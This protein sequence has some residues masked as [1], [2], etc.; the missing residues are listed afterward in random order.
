MVNA[1]LDVP[2][3][4][5]RGGTAPPSKISRSTGTSKVTRSK[6]L[7]SEND[8]GDDLAEDLS[9]DVSDDPN[10]YHKKTAKAIIKARKPATYG[11]GNARTAIKAMFTPGSDTGGEDD[12]GQEGDESDTEYVAAGAPFLDYPSGSE[13]SIVVKDEVDPPP[14]TNAV[15]PTIRKLVKLRIPRRYAHQVFGNISDVSTGGPGYQ[16]RNGAASFQVGA[17]QIDVSQFSTGPFGFQNQPPVNLQRGHPHSTTFPFLNESFGNGSNSSPPPTGS[18][19]QDCVPSYRGVADPLSIGTSAAEQFQTRGQN[20]VSN[21]SDIYYPQT[22][23]P[24]QHAPTNA[25]FS[26][27]AGPGELYDGVVPWDG[28]SG[29]NFAAGEP[30]NVD[31]GYLNRTVLTDSYED[32]LNEIVDSGY[33]IFDFSGK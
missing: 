10:Q 30:N 1:G 3:P 17:S 5:R 22:R 21:A 29:A 32:I 24:Y 13:T 18:V 19:L 23:N 7:V 31:L 27:T 16:R 8:F 6:K 25:V 33:D 20:I 2:P 9:D 11:S 12:A 26:N 15:M 28:E 14:C 4:L